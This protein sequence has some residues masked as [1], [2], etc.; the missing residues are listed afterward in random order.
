MCVCVFVT[1]VCKGKGGGRCGEGE[2]ENLVG[3]REVGK[4]REIERQ[5]KKRER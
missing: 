1:E 3:S 4:K 5:K 2:K